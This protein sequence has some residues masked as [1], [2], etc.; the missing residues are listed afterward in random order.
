[1]RLNVNKLKLKRENELHYIGAGTSITNDKAEMM[2]SLTDQNDGFLFIYMSVEEATKL[3][4]NWSARIAA[5]KI[6]TIDK[7]PY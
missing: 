7:L 4:E 5:L 1:M 2:L 6:P 3:I